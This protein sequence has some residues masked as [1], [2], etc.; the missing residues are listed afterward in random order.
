MEHFHR[1]SG[2]HGH[3]HAEAED[4]AAE[5]SEA[6]DQESISDD[7]DDDDDE[8]SV[9]SDYY[10]SSDEESVASDDSGGS[11]ETSD[12]GEEIINRLER[13][14]PHLTEICLHHQNE[15]FPVN[16]EEW[17]DVG[18]VLGN[19]T[20]ITELSIL[21][22]FDG[23]AISMTDEGAL[24]SGLQ[25]NRSIQ[26]LHFTGPL[27]GMFNFV[28]PSI[29]F[30]EENENLRMLDLNGLELGLREMTILCSVIAKTKN[31]VFLGITHCWSSDHGCFLGEDEDLFAAF[32]RALRNM[33]H[34]LKRL[35]L[36]G[37]SI[38]FTAMNKLVGTIQRYHP[39]LEDLNLQDNII[40]YFSCNAVGTLLRDPTSRLSVLDLWSCSMHDDCAFLLADALKHNEVFQRVNLGANSFTMDGWQAFSTLLCNKTSILG[41]IRSNHTIQCLD[42]IDLPNELDEYLALN[43]FENKREV[44]LYKVVKYHIDELVMMDVELLPNIIASMGKVQKDTTTEIAC[45]MLTSL[46]S[47]VHNI[48]GL[49]FRS[50]QDVCTI[51]D[52]LDKTSF[53]SL[54]KQGTVANLADALDRG[55]SN[56]R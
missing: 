38:G 17:F 34:S 52:R 24:H 28:H 33:D 5:R 53:S 7:D 45:D 9:A 41:T 2:Y 16:E 23:E 44:A 19:N 50:E 55:L 47:I 51:T 37:N 30:W 43:R 31:V 6:Y 4:S 48:P 13:N 26:E 56:L 36:Q 12:D 11:W 54:S 27:P 1:D 18:R 32:L 15:W 35:E 42:A 8:V 10:T 29:T 39:E 3:D 49:L 46:F 22:T 40:G 25:H 21:N 20:H 14:D